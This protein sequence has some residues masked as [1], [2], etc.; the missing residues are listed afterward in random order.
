MSQGQ[1]DM[2]IKQL[3]KALKKAPSF[4]DAYFLRAKLYEAKGGWMP[5]AYLHIQ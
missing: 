2:A 1:F 3:T 4:T 5:Y